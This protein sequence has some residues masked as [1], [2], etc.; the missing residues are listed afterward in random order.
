[1]S[2]LLALLAAI[3]V[4]LQEVEGQ[5]PTAGAGSET[6][7]WNPD[8]SR[9]VASIFKELPT[10]VHHYDGVSEA[11]V[12][13]RFEADV[14]YQTLMRDKLKGLWFAALVSRQ[15]EG[16]Y[17]IHTR[18]GTWR[19]LVEFLSEKNALV[20]VWAY[21]EAGVH[22]AHRIPA[23]ELAMLKRQAHEQPTYVTVSYWDQEIGKA[24]SFN[25]EFGF[26]A[27]QEVFAAET[28]YQRH[29]ALQLSAREI[30]GAK[31]ASGLPDALKQ[32][33]ALQT[34]LLQHQLSILE[35]PPLPTNPKDIFVAFEFE[36]DDQNNFSRIIR[37]YRDSEV[38]SKVVGD[39]QILVVRKADEKNTHEVVSFGRQGLSE[40]LRPVPHSVTGQDVVELR[41]QDLSQPQTNKW[42]VLEFGE[43]EV[44]K[45]SSLAHFALLNAYLERNRKARAMTQANVA[46]VAEPIIAALNVGGALAG[47]GFPAGEPARLLYNLITWKLISNVPSAKQMRE[48]F[49]LMAARDRNPSIKLKPERFLARADI[50]TLEQAGGKLSNQEIEAYLEVMSDEDVRAMLRLARMG[51]FDAR[52]TTFLNTLA[53]VFKISG[54]ADDPGIIRDIFNNVRFSVNGE[55]N[56]STL[57]LLALGKDV[58]TPLSGESLQS[59]SQGQGPQDAWLQYLVLS[60]DIRAVLNTIVRLTKSTLAKKELEKPFPYAPRMSELAA[61]EIRIFGFPLLMFY[62]R[63]LIQDD[64]EAYE[65]DYAYG[66]YGVRLVEHFADREGME[67]EIR[68]GRMFPLGLVKVPAA[69]GGW[70]ETDLVVYGHRVTQGRFRGKTVLVIYGLKAYTEYSELIARELKRFKEYERGLREGAVIEQRVWED[71]ASSSLS[72][73]F[74]PTV[75]AG[76]NAVQEVFAPLLGALLEFRRHSLRQSWGLSVDPAEFTQVKNRLADLGVQLV[77]PDPL[78]QVDNYN[79]SFIYRRQVGKDIQTFRMTAIPGLADIER[80]MRK[81]E[82]GKLIEEMRAEAAAGHSHG[83]VLL[84]EALSVNGHFEVGPLL[85][86]AKEQVVGTGVTSGASAIDS[87]F[88]LINRLPVID[89]ARLRANHFTGTVVELD[90]GGLKTK[91]FLTIEFPLG[92]VRQDLT[93]SLSGEIETE[94]YNDGLWRET[95]TNRR[96]VE[97]DYDDQEIEVGSCTYENRGNR[98]APIRGVLLEETKTLSVWHRDMHQPALDPHQPTIAKLHINYVTGQLSSESFG[99]FRLPVEISDD[100]YVTVN[101]YDHYGVFESATVFENGRDETDFSR[102]FA[103]QVLEPIQGR[104]RFRL[105]ARSNSDSIAGALSPSSHLSAVERLDLIKGLVRTETFDNSHFGR[106]VREDHQD[107]F[108]G[109]QSFSRV[110]NWEY[111]DDFHFGLLPVRAVTFGGSLR[112]KL[113]EVTTLH[114]DSASR[115]LVGM[116]VDYAGKT[117]TNTWSYRWES[118]IETETSRRRTVREYNRDETFSHSTTIAKSPNQTI[119]DSTGNYELTNK[120]WEVARQVWYQPGVLDHT[121]TNTYSAFGLLI[122]SRRVNAFE[123]RPSYTSEGIEETTWTFQR[124]SSTSRVDVLVRQQGDYHWHNGARTARVQVY[125]DGLVSDEYQITAD[126][127]GRAIEDQVRVRPSLSLKTTLTYDGDTDRVTNSKVLQNDRVRTAYDTLG[128]IQRPSGEWLLRVKAVPAWGLVFT[129]SYVLGDPRGVAFQTEFENGDRSRITDWGPNSS[130]AQVSEVLDRQGHVKERFVKRP[131]FGIAAGFPYESFR[132]FKVSPWGQLGQAEEKALVRGTDVSLFC[133]KSDERIYFDLSKPYDCPRYAVDPRGHFGLQVAIAGTVR[134]NVTAIFSGQFGNRSDPRTVAQ[135]PE[136]VFNLAAI[137]FQGF[138]FHPFS[139]R[140]FDR[141]GNMLE[142]SAGSIRNLGARAYS[143]VVL[144]SEMAKVPVT[145]KTLYRYQPGLF[146]EKRFRELTSKAFSPRASSNAT[147][148]VINGA[149]WREWPTEVNNFEVAS[150]SDIARFY[151]SRRAHS[152]RWI[153]RNPYLPSCTNVWTEWTSD[154]LDENGKSLCKSTTI[155]NAAGELATSVAHKINSQGQLADKI[156]YHLPY[157]SDWQNITIPAG[158]NEIRL[159][160]TDAQDFSDCDFV[161]FYLDAPGTANVRVYFQDARQR[162][163]T[164]ADSTMAPRPDWLRFRPVGTAQVSWLPNPATPQRGFAVVAPRSLVEER[165][166]FVISVPELAK[167]G[168]SLNRVT[169]IELLVSKFNSTSLKVTPLYRLASTEHSLLRDLSPDFVFD[170]QSHSSGLTIDRRTLGGLA[171][172]AAREGR[173]WNSTLTFEGISVGTL[174]PRLEPP[175]FP[176]LQ[177]VDSSN[178]DITRPLYSMAADDGQFL[179]YF[180]TAHSGDIQVANIVHGFDTPKLEIFRSGILDDELSPGIVVFGHGYYLTVPMTKGSGGIFNVLAALHNRCIASVFGLTG[181]RLFQK[182]ADEPKPFP[183]EQ[184]SAASQAKYIDQLPTLAEALLPRRLVPWEQT[185]QPLLAGLAQPDQASALRELLRLSKVFPQ[186]RSLIPTSP[187][188]EV[189]S[190]VDTVQE[191]GIINLAVT[192]RNLSLARELL[193]FYWEK[194]QGGK[195]PLHAFYDARSGASLTKRTHYQRA[196]DSEMTASAQ[197]AIADAAFCL[198]TATDD[199]TAL[200]FGTNLVGLVFGTF[201]PKTNEVS[202]PRGIAEKPVKPVQSLRSL[203]LWPEAKLFSLGSNARA[204]LL[205]THLAEQGDRFAFTP[206]WKQAIREAAFEQAAWITNRFLP[207]VA[208]TGV[209]PK[210]LFELQDVRN[211]LTQFALDRW[212]TSD[213]WLSFIEA[214]ERM[215]LSRQLTRGWLDNLARA[216]GVTVN[217]VWGLDWTIALARPDAISPE[218]TA[219]FLKVADLLGHDQA[220]NFVEQNLK[221]LRQGDNW[222]A[223]FTTASTDAPMKTG[224]ASEVYPLQSQR[225]KDAQRFVTNQWPAT[226]GVYAE[227]SGSAWPTNLQAGSSMEIRPTSPRDIIQFLWTAAGFYIAMIVVTLFWWVLSWVRKRQRMK[228]VTAANM[229]LLV[230]EVVMQKAEERWARRVLGIRM[231]TGA[232]CSRY[233]NA[234]IEQNFH[235]QLR[236]IYKLVLEWRRVVNGWPENDA[237]LVEEGQD[238]WLNGLDEFAV[239]IGIYTRWVVKAGR[240]DGLPKPN[241]LLENEDSNHIWSRLVIYFSDSHLRLLGLMADFQSNPAAAAVLGVNDEIE[242]ALRLMGA[243]ARP[244]AFDA[245][246]AFDAPADRSAM[247]I[248]LIQ[249]PG[250]GLTRIVEE[251]ELKLDIPA[252]HVLSFIRGYKSFKEREHLYPVHPYI[253]EAAKMLPHFVFMGLVAVIWYNNGL[254][255]LRIYDYLKEAA[256]RMAADA[257]SLIWAVPLFIGCAL[258]VTAYALQIYRYRWPTQPLAE[259]RMALDTEVTGLF[260][261]STRIATPAMHVGLLWNPLIYQRLGWIFRA[262]G[263]ALLAAAIF[264]L[265]SPSFATWVTVKGL[266]GVV[267]LLESASLL[268]PIISARFSSWLEDRVSASSAPGA[269]IRWVNQLNLVPTRPASLVWLSLKYHF[270]PSVPTGS[271]KAMVQAI[272]FYLVFA[273]TFFFIGGYM[274]NQALE[275]WFQETYRAGWDI[276]LILGAGLFWITMYLLRFGVFVL[277]AAFSSALAVYPFKVVGALVAVGCLAWQLVSDSFNQYLRDHQVFTCVGLAAVLVAITCESAILSR[278]GRGLRP[279]NRKAR[280]ANQSLKNRNKRD[281]TLGVVYM[282]GDDLSSQKLT[283]DLLMT[284]LA[285]LREKLGSEGIRL[286]L[287]MQSLPEDVSLRQWLAS[288]YELEMKHDVS[289]WH[290]LQL[291]VGGEQ[292][293]FREQLGLTLVVDSS[294]QRE[295][296]LTAW[297]LRRWLVTMMSTAGH[298]QDT[299][300]NLVDIALSLHHEGLAARSVFYLIQNKY[301]NNET[302]R[303]SQMAYDRGE[304]GHRNKLAHLLMELAPGS[305][306]YSLNDWTPFGFKAGGLVGMDLVPE[307]TL[308]LTNMLVLDRNANTHDLDALMTDVKMALGDPGVVIV[309]PGRSTTNTLTPI[310]QGSQL[311]EEGHRALIRGVMMLGGSGAENMGTGWGNLQAIYYGPVQRALCDVRT[312]KVPLTTPS[313]RGASFGDRFEG[314]IGFGP[315]AIG[316]SE[317]IWGVTQAAHNALA[318]GHQVRFCRSRALWHKVRETWSHA[319]WLAAFPRWS[320]G[321]LQMMLDPIMQRIN[322]DGPLSAFAKEI[323]A[324]GGRFFLGAPVALLSI[325]LMPLA[326]IWDLSPFVQILILLWNLGLVM[327]QVLTSLGLVACL[328][329]TG[330]NRIT[331]FVGL[332]A[333]GIALVTY[334]DLRPFFLPVFLFGFLIGGFAIGLGRWLFYRGRDMVLFGPQLVIHA[335]GQVTRQSLEF[336]LSGASAN[337]AKAVNMAFRTWVGPRED[338]PFETYQNFVNLRT[339][340]W[341]V[342]LT[343]LLLNLFA[344]ANLDF[345]NVLLLLP[346]LMFSVSTL[347]GPF[348]MQPKPG[349]DLGWTVWI[350]KS[351]G[352]LASFAFYLVVACLISFGGWLQWLGVLLCLAT[353]GRLLSVGLKYVGYRKRLAKIMVHMSGAMSEGGLPAAEARKLAE[354]LLQGLGGDVEKSRLALQ[355]SP[356]RPDT[357]ALVLQI[358]RDKAL[359]LLRKPITDLEPPLGPNPRFRSEW[360]RSFVLGLFTFVWFFVVPMPG[361]LVFIAPQGYRVSLSPASM[362]YFAA[363]LVVVVLVGGALSLFLDWW[364]RKRSSDRGLVAQIQSRYRSFVYR[365]AQVG[366]LTPRQTSHLYAMFTDVQTFFDQRSYAYARTTLERIDHTLKE[367]DEAKKRIQ[368]DPE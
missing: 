258:S 294:T 299:A 89:R 105:N 114:Y 117:Q 234:P 13:R 256:T 325:L 191:A 244:N 163:V 26:H 47:L 118:P 61:Y 31:N 145:R 180:Q 297:H 185:E 51:M 270:Q 115:R 217:G 71:P 255:G 119:D 354:R 276:R 1:M 190:Y 345:L 330:F 284:R 40:R 193:A 324:N 310:G 246:S 11:D 249:L 338:R 222:P 142:E 121:E 92:Q 331:G 206:E 181:H 342:G 107:S 307:E 175:H 313:Q 162:S 151:H 23:Q 44:L 363:G 285:L 183:R 160:F 351:L 291:V 36:V 159:K 41:I 239:M 37:V 197:L 112:T 202:W 233:S 5:S 362:L 7:S 6:N 257:H 240:K 79:S 108:D 86:D 203:T 189:E 143:D 286:L 209:V 45:Q 34:R 4:Q 172:T 78:V 304:L 264:N 95:V 311:I 262:M 279:H 70:K 14:S 230:S 131:G 96:I 2:T 248:L 315:H 116:E 169:S 56:L 340:V 91:V 20:E 187:G 10:L 323:R 39:S 69:A 141:A 352:W 201:R 80:E 137:E 288:L 82:E 64:R 156:V 171:S 184:P 146:E 199:K 263:L 300:I 166:A 46:L 268:G 186:G 277:F 21:G 358:V 123:V 165:K 266:V 215:G 344:L 3:G 223:V 104:P 204:Y 110:V 125:T 128:V 19:E 60:V 290:P 182:D 367:T 164:V 32:W 253:L 269:F 305:R 303:P 260:G 355:N 138:F 361:L 84:N 319:E 210:G 100:Q 235:L 83:V 25:L 134:S 75:H 356:L 301:D 261:A 168:L 216:H 326:I 228:A 99:L 98:L 272:A 77:T 132:R 52:I 149:G 322:D 265:E 237:R 287:K 120:T 67:A 316:I 97:P 195:S 49:A 208:A 365:A 321:Y 254:R 368:T 349:A 87:I 150:E 177:L 72:R 42:H 29:R 278:I 334:Q 328:E 140:T 76:S 247:D 227:L 333:S 273:A 27:A 327:N 102:S 59:L 312:P 153:E 275:V 94:V 274:Y 251:M 130:T 366:S 212:T 126:E 220:S 176:V 33:A 139:T 68:A 267:L 12:K 147:D 318:L 231:A 103:A 337:D 161:G 50:Q 329:S 306:A 24:L 55:I 15:D 350:P 63:G 136:L 229:G 54:L 343:S 243:R 218:L 309:I 347:V 341:G 225:G 360:N 302:N 178:P 332:T 236:A 221:K 232:D 213:D 9:T 122:R 339:V 167:A 211:Q 43:P 335:L 65:H 219:R 293:S 148:W 58:M 308:K 252:E 18:F 214:A 144:F 295:Q 226:L 242:L 74:E 314:L 296:I 22:S 364:E 283:A 200:T 317:D 135:I 62:K 48:L 88:E 113:A 173:G 245:R 124:S 133:E 359:P 238:P 357:Q 289:L 101:R 281:C 127:E 282:S 38:Q 85:C 205:L 174:D 179:N 155:L 57:L 192:V 109:M 259:S 207:F 28:A 154:D 66:L 30:L 17:S 93:N 298:S 320:G 292:A 16:P 157:P 241:V 35:V 250:V 353:F 196:S 81:A 336:V 129:N 271:A 280:Q 111:Q 158:T 8:L 106:K 198:A 73:N 152:P 90:H 188:T 194:S 224:Q 348:L 170:A 53:S 346:T